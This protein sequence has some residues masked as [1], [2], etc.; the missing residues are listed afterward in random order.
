MIFYFSLF[1]FDET[2]TDTI[3]DVSSALLL[4]VRSFDDQLA[5]KADQPIFFYD[6]PSILNKYCDEQK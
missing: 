4:K 6:C 5:Q 3:T 2:K 1:P